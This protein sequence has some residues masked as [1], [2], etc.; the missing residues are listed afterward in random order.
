MFPLSIKSTHDTSKPPGNI[1][2][3]LFFCIFILSFESCRF[4]IAVGLPLLIVHNTSEVNP[5]LL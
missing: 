5:Y 2:P 4:V 1:N 3:V